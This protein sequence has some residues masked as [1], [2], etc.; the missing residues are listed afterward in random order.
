MP[1]ELRK[2]TSRPNY[3]A[4]AEGEEDPEAGPSTIPQPEEEEE[5]ASGSDFAPE[6]DA[7]GQDE[8]EEEAEGGDYHGQSE[9][10]ECVTYL[11]N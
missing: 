9:C 1:R 4:L 5:D 10:I 11:T 6:N 2:R 8:E 3:A 7:E